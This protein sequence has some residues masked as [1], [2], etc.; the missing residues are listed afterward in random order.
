MAEPERASKRDL[1]AGADVSDMIGVKE[2]LW[3]AIWLLAAILCFFLVGVVVGII[4][5][6]VGTIATLALF[7][8]IIRRADTSD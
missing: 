5:V 3:L 8:N 6:V 4:V 7:V 2:T 1:S